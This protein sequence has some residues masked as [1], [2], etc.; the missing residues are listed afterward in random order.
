[1]IAA[2]SLLRGL[3]C[4]LFLAP[5]ALQ[6]TGE[7]LETGALCM[8]QHQQ[9]DWRFLVGVW[10]DQDDVMAGNWISKEGLQVM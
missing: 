1:M 10:S 2:L 8:W 4:S 5:F 6:E 3:F 7:W 9:Q